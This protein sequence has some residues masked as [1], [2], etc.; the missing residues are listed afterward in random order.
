MSKRR[1]LFGALVLALGTAGTLAWAKVKQ[2]QRRESVRAFMRPKL[3]H[4]QKLLEG[5]TLEQ[6]DVVK[7]EAQAL[8]LLSREEEWNVLQ[9]EDYLHYSSEFRRAADAVRDAAAKKNLDGAALAYLEMTMK[10]ITCHKYVRGVR[11][12]DTGLPFQAPKFR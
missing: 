3:A 6:F 7:Q 5:L 9:T 2:D 4:A 1:L 8:S 11:M 10:C 12:A